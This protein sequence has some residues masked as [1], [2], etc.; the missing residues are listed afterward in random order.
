M[1]ETVKK[2]VLPPSLLSEIN[3][4]EEG[5]LVRYRIKTENKNLS[6]HWS[7]VYTV[8]LPEFG[9]VPGGLS[10]STGEG[11]QIVISAVWDDVL[12]FFSYDV[13]VAFRGG[14]LYGDEFEYD[15]D[16]FHFHGT[17]QDHNYSFIQ[18]PGSTFLR[19][20]VQPSTNIKKIKERFIVFDSDNPVAEES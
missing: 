10:V 8:P 7:P 3:W 13:Y 18:I 11:G 16:L 17:T 9:A 2:V 5:Y 4:E 15:N 20:I 19:V 1:P 12:D 14:A 6:S